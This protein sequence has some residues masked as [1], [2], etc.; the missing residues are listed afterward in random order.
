MS[1]SGL[2]LSRRRP[3]AALPAEADHPSARADDALGDR[4]WPGAEHRGATYVVDRICMRQSIVQPRVVALAHHGD[5]DVVE[6][7]RR[8]QLAQ[9]SMSPSQARPTCMVEVRT[10]GVRSHPSSRTSMAEVSSPAPLRTATPAGNASAMSATG[11]PGTTAVTPARDTAAGRRVGLVAPH[12]GV[13]H[14]D[15][16][17]VGDRVA[18]PVGSPPMSIPRSRR[19]GR[20]RRSGHASTSIVPDGFWGIA[21]TA[22]KGI[23]EASALVRQARSGYGPGG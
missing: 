6:T 7:E 23:S 18:G 16:G 9:H 3:D 4:P 1:P 22:A 17:D 2:E 5:D 15:A 11:G 12:R 10:I 13:A 8:I 19:R 20:G 21:A 14:Q